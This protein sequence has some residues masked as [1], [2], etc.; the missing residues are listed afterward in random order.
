MSR[1]KKLIIGLVIVFL[2]GGISSGLYFFHFKP[3]SSPI[4]AELTKQVPFQIYYPSDK[5]YKLVKDSLY[6]DSSL[7]L[8]YMK[9][10]TGTDLLT[11]TEQAKPADFNSSDIEGTQF[12]TIVGTGIIISNIADRTTSLASNLSIK[13]ITGI[14]GILIT[15][16]V[17]ISINTQ[18]DERDLQNFI[19]SFVAK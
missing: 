16:T 12:L 15:P 3:S 8:L 2:L 14:P 18:K 6:Y 9:F 17:I 4:S 7:Q 13:R 1:K 10:Q 19:S 11:I 5:K